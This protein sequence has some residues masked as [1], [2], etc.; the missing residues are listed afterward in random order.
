VEVL[1]AALKRARI[2]GRLPPPLVYHHGLFVTIDFN[3]IVNDK[4]EAT[5]A[6]KY[7]LNNADVR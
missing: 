3:V 1:S 5:L 4:G 2:S 6:V 7:E